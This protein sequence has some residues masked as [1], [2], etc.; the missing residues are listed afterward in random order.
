[1]ARKDIVGHP[2]L[3]DWD[4]KINLTG[5]LFKLSQKRAPFLSPSLHITN[6]VILNP[7]RVSLVG[8]EPKMNLT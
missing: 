1:M 4:F 7:G 2:C 8:K 5:C 3:L 6:C